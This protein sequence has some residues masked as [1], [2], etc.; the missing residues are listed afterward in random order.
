MGKTAAELFGVLRLYM[1]W[2]SLRIAPI[3]FAKHISVKN[4]RVL[5][6]YVSEIPPQKKNTSTGKPRGST[7]PIPFVEQRRADAVSSRKKKKHG[8]I[9]RKWQMLKKSQL[10]YFLKGSHAKKQQDIKGLRFTN[11]DIL[12]QPEDNFSE[13]LCTVCK[14]CIWWYLQKVRV[15]GST[16]GRFGDLACFPEMGT[17][18]TPSLFKR[19]NLSSNLFLSRAVLVSGSFILKL[20]SNWGSGTNFERDPWR[21]SGELYGL[22]MLQTLKLPLT[23]ISH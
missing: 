3:W 20:S 21:D 8:W 5:H 2:G 16:V 1:I 11:L 12:F 7:P 9:R 13:Y 19:K 4:L 10:A 6:R 14:I 22:I 15:P 23:T 18:Q 17:L